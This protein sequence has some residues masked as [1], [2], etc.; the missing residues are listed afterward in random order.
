MESSKHTANDA[1][2]TPGG[3]TKTSGL[4][5]RITQL[6]REIYNLMNLPPKS[7]YIGLTFNLVFYMFD[8]VNKRKGGIYND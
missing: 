4:P 1:N 7:L 5:W 3:T 2:E 6:H 8:Y